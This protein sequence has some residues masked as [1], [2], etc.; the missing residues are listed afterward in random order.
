MHISQR[1]LLS[2]FSDL[3]PEWPKTR[4]LN[5]F[6]S[7]LRESQLFLV[8]LSYEF[9]NDMIVQ[10]KTSSI[11]NRELFEVWIELGFSENWEISLYI[12]TDEKVLCWPRVRKKWHP[13]FLYFSIL[14]WKNH[15]SKI[16]SWPQTIDVHPSGNFFWRDRF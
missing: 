15:L 8:F 10:P 9:K 16:R 3:T 7:A 5:L 12:Q 4:I 1:Q 2:D 14:T 13:K 6:L 11:A